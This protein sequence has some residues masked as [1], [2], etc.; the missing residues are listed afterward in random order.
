MQTPPTQKSAVLCTPPP[1]GGALHKERHQSK[2]PTKGSSDNTHT[3]KRRRRTT[4]TPGYTTPSLCPSA[5][6]MRTRF[7]HTDFVQMYR[8]LH[9]VQIGDFGHYLTHPRTTITQIKEKAGSVP[10]HP[11]RELATTHNPQSRGRIQ[12]T[13]VAH[14]FPQGA[15]PLEVARCATS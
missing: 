8:V 7:Y 2:Q 5:N 14:Q 4:P 12:H 15:R 11:K 9:V 3:H 13:V 10:E 6:R 1:T